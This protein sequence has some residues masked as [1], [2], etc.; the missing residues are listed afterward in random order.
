M[1]EQAASYLRA[2]YGDDYVYR[3]PETFGNVVERWIWAVAAGS[4][5]MADECMTAIETHMRERRADA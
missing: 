3:A 4:L 2:R 1:Q 5:A